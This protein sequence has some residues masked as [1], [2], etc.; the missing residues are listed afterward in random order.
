VKFKVDGRELDATGIR[1][2][3]LCE[4]EKALQLNMADGSGAAIAVSLFVALRRENKTKP[5][6]MVADEVMRADVSSFEEAD[7]ESPPAEAADA[8]DAETEP[9]LENQLTSGVRS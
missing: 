2:G 6:A 4:A 5:A 9:A 8:A 7:E 3:E 1:V